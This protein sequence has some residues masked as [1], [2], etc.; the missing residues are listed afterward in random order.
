LLHRDISRFVQTAKT[1]KMDVSITT[2]GVLLSPKRAD[3][4]IPH[5]SWIRF[6]I[7]AGTPET[8]AQIH[9][10]RKEDFEKVMQN[11]AYAAEIKR[12]NNLG[13]TIGTQ[14]LLTSMSINELA[15]LA[16]RLKE[17]GA[18]NLQIKPYSH[19]PSS[20]NDLSFDYQEAEKIRPELESLSDEK[21]EVIYRAKTIRRLTSRREYDSCHGL[22]FFALIDCKANV[23]PCNIFYGQKEFIYGNLKNNLFSEIWKSERRKQVIKRINEKGIGDCRLGCRLDSSNRYLHR[24]RHPHPHDN[25]L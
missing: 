3:E 14:A 13:V 17:I 9:R 6:S 11:I 2:N 16:R 20:K 1:K 19:H 15:I 4:I 25:F 21:F 22:P 10:T 12:K 5:L 7:D 24:I 18:D 8:Y 23:I